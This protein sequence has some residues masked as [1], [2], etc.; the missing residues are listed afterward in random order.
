MPFTGA[1]ASLPGLVI[2]SFSPPS[3]ESLGY[4]LPPCRAWEWLIFGWESPN[5]RHCIASSNASPV[6]DAQSNNLARRP[7]WFV[8]SGTSDHSPPFQRWDPTSRAS[9][10]KPRQGRKKLLSC[11]A[12]PV[13]SDRRG[14]PSIS[15]R[16]ALLRLCVRRAWQSRPT[17]RRARRSRPT[18]VPKPRQGRKKIPGLSCARMRSYA[19]HRSSCVPAGTRV[20]VV[21]PTQR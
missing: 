21:Q 15:N 18:P 10:S 14:R 4:F 2:R 6:R 13:G 20:P 12:R 16:F 3:D 11:A 9:P 5:R 1:L 8:P 19:S 7:A 17:H